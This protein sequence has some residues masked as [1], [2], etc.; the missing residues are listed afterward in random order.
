MAKRGVERERPYQAHG[1]RRLIR[2]PTGSS[3]PSGHAAV[4]TAVA[5][6]LADHGRGRR[7]AAAYGVAAYVAVSRVHLGVHYPTDVIGGAGLGLLLAAVW[8]GPH[9]RA[10]HR[11][12][13][14]AAGAA[15]RRRRR[16]SPQADRTL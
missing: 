16:A 13:D 8:C 4:S 7:S 1:V 3:F 5:A 2:E 14:L 10:L 12:T 6:A 9:R 11:L 15:A